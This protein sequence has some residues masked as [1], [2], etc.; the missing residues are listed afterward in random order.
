MKKKSNKKRNFVPSSLE[1]SNSSNISDTSEEFSSFDDCESDVSHDFQESASDTE[2]SDDEKATVLKKFKNIFNENLNYRRRKIRFS[3]LDLSV[4]R[5]WCHEIC[6]MDTFNSTQKIQVHNY[7][8]SFNYHPVHIRNQSLQEY[9]KIFIKSATYAIWQ[10]ENKKRNKKEEKLPTIGFR[11][12]TNAFCP[13]CLNQKQ[14]DCE[15]HV[16]VSLMN[17]LKALGSLRRLQGISEAIQVGPGLGM[18]ADE[19]VSKNGLNNGM[20]AREKWMDKSVDDLRAAN[21]QKASGLGLYGYEGPAKSSITQRGD[22]GIVENNRVNKTFEMGQDR[23]LTT[24]GIEKGHKLRP[25]QVE[26]NVNRAETSSDYVGAAGASNSAQHMEGTLYRPS[27]N[28]E[29]GALPILPAYA[30]GKS[31]AYDGDYGKKTSTVYNNNRST[32]NDSQSYYGGV[33]GTFGSI[34][35][36]ILDILRPSRRENVIGSMRPYQN[37]KTPV[38]NSY[39]YNSNDRPSTTNRELT[40]NSKSHMNMTASKIGGY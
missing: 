12:F 1:K 26:R 29:L 37:A 38:S 8:G 33:G 35:S 6:R 24:G 19:N 17:A 28:I 30:A 14:R 3:K 5:D 18:G 21:K 16:Q 2:L 13:C 39:I 25:L 10:N 34:F 11:S 20:M 40:E 9:F 36:P 15:N 7:D 32:C 4:V 31:G 27:T 22:I 23:L